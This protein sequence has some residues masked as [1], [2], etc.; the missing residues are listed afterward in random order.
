MMKKAA[1]T[2]LTIVAMAWTLPAADAPSPATK[3]ALALPTGFF[4]MTGGGWGTY[5]D[6]FKVCELDKSQLSKVADIEAQRKAAV[7]DKDKALTT[8]QQAFISAWVSKDK[9]A[10]AKTQTV[11]SELWKVVNDAAAKTQAQTLA[12]LTPQQKAKWME[13]VALKSV[14]T[15]YYADVKF[16]DKQWDTIMELYEKM[17]KDSSVPSDQL[18]YKFNMKIND[19]LTPE[20]KAKRIM[21]TRYAMMDKTVH[22]TPE[23]IA[24]LVK[25]EDDR[26]KATVEIQDK[27]NAR[28][29]QSQKTFAD[30]QA[31]GSPDALAAA[32]AQWADI[33]KPLTDLNTQLDGEVQTVMTE[34]QKTAWADQTKKWQARGQQPGGGVMIDL[35]GGK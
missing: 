15:M 5:E 11:Y 31:S 7:K 3:S 9:D 4:S 23:Q 1:W 26:N 18:I 14:K 21:A 2:V 29:A 35:H 6:L 30:A 34:K 10:I 24:K 33:Y 8:A 25:I 20:Q 13:Y 28:L 22:F 32:Q 27:I 17:A 12:V 19:I 16:T